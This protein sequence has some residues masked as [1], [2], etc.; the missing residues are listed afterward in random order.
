MSSEPDAIRTAQDELYL[1]P[2]YTV[3]VE[4]NGESEIQHNRASGSWSSMGKCQVA[5]QFV[6]LWHAPCAERRQSKGQS[7]FAKMDVAPF[8]MTVYPRREISARNAKR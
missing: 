3:T 4:G 7:M 5:I 6:T 8:A 1:G 2:R